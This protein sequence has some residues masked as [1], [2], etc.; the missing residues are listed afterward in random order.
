M[1]QSQRA[2]YRSLYKSYILSS[3]V[4]RPPAS[5]SVEIGQSVASRYAA[6]IRRD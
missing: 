2:R 6:F 4:T 5:V 3:S 1:S